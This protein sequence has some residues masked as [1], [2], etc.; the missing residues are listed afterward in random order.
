MDE[1]YKQLIAPFP[2]GSVERTKKE[3]TRKGYDTTGYKY[4]Y[5][6][7]RFNEVF[8]IEG[9]SFTWEI[10]RE[11]EGKWKSGSAF[12][13]ITV[14][15][16]I[17]VL[18]K[19]N[20]SMAGG[21]ISSLYCDALKG[22]ITN[23]FKKCAAMY[24]VGGDAYKGIIDDDNIP[25]IEKP[26]SVNTNIENTKPEEKTGTYFQKIIAL[27]NSNTLDGKKKVECAKVLNNNRE[28]EIKLK[29]LYETMTEKKADDFVDDL[30]YKKEEEKLDIF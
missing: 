9:W 29:L 15:V 8:G 4:Q 20:R 10:I 7:D 11:K 17:N 1:K 28:N 19:T 5:L 23:A 2:E 3:Q 12:F 13:D 6:V 25:I 21:H 18:E 22:A 16:N 26:N 24:G 30:P 27:L 14:K